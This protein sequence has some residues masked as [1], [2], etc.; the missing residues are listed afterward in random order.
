MEADRRLSLTVGAF[1][2][3]SLAAFAF[4]IVSLSTRS[5]VWAPRYRLVAFFDNVQGLIAGAPVWLAG[6]PV[7]RVE[8]VNF[9][10]RP[11][12]RPALEVVM[13]VDREVRER[14]RSDSVATIGTIGLLGDRYVEV[15]IGTTAGRPLEDGE[16][17]ATITRLDLGSVVAKGTQ[18]LDSISTLAA[19]LNQVIEGFGKEGGGE[20]LA[21]SM[22]AFRAIV[23]QIQDGRGLL[24]SLIYDEYTGGGGVESIERSLVRMEK[25]L[26]EID[27]GEGILHSL[28]YDAPTEQDL[29]IEALEAG[30]RLNSILAKVD[31]GEGTLGLI[32]NDPTLYEDLKLL[33]GGANRSAVVRGMIRSLSD[34]GK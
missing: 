4:A 28:I 23:S 15:S 21:S 20:S 31:R 19:N 26:R 2:L 16:E 18:A 14:I 32:V 22:G 24:H 29:V 9:G 12:G 13:Q 3:V 34:D 11:E 1:A 27:E 17:L 30:A 33:V 7:G 6:R 10:V 5:G 8:S 25:I